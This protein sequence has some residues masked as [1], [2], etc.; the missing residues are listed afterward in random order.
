MSHTE[1]TPTSTRLSTGS[2]AY[3]GWR[4]SARSTHQWHA[5]LAAA[6]AT[7]SGAVGAMLCRSSKVVS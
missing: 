1:V 2:A 6:A 3:H 7:T 4:R 5:P